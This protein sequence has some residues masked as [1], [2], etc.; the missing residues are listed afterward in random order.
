MS[1]RDDVEIL[2]VGDVMVKR[3]EPVTIM[4]HVWDVLADPGNISFA[5]CESTYA[6]NASKNP[7]TRGVVLAHP[8][9]VEA[10]K[11]FDV[12][13]FANNHH[14]D[15]GYEAFFETLEH[16]AAAGIAVCGAGKDL[17]EARRPTVV[18]RN[19]VRV[20][21]LGYSSILFPGYEAGRGK[22]G[23]APLRADTYYKLVE[24]EQPG[25]RPEILTFTDR[26]DLAAM[27]EDVRRAKEVADVVVVSPHWGIH[28]LP[29]DVAD[30]ETEAARAAIDAGADAVLGH[31]Q[32]ILKGVQVYKGKPIFHGMGN[33]ALDVYMAQHQDSPALQEMRARYPDYAVGHRDETPTYPF[34]PEAR[35]TGIFKCRVR[36]GQVVGASVVPCMINGD[37]Q[38]VPLRAG[39]PD[40]DVVTAYLAEIS[41]RAGF[42][43]RF[44]VRDDELA[45]LPGPGA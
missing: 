15:A 44:E 43:T 27:V 34:H 16:L 2:A 26:H 36:D 6:V 31:H 22:P 14:L 4:A 5:N 10:L 23:C 7:A 8:K 35:R 40:F 17:D 41:R 3:E 12:M 33:F 39:Q 28:F 1:D 38:P 37:G 32:H 21:F 30:Y 19:G 9:N 42:D 24:V 18:E 25:S 29:V 13:S 11:C 45:V 20:A